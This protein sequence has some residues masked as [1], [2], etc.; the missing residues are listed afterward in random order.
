MVGNSWFV[1]DRSL[2]LVSCPPHPHGG[3]RGLVAASRGGYWSG[4]T[5]C[6]VAG[7][8]AAA[9][10]NFAFSSRR[11]CTLWLPPSGTND[12]IGTWSGRVRAYL[13]VVRLGSGDR[14][15]DRF[16]RAPPGKGR[17]LRPESER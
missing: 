1:A 7:M 17:P 16:A 13:G 3:A 15:A 9:G 10:C 4:R 8:V 5:R 12:C 14:P 2:L 6:L 11:D